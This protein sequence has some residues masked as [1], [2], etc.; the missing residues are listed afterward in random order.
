MWSLI[1]PQRRHQISPTISGVML[2]GLSMGIGTA[3]YN[4]SNNILF[5]ALSLLLA[6]LILSGVLSWLNLM[7]VAWRLLLLPP[8]RVGQQS[9][10]VLELRN[11]KRFLP[12]YGLSFGLCAR[13]VNSVAA[14]AE[15]TFIA[16]S[17]DVRAA[18]AK[19][20]AIDAQGRLKLRERLEPKGDVRLEWALKPA[21]R[22]RLRVEL[23]NVGSLFPFG[24]LKKQVGTDLGTAVVVWPAPI[25][26]RRFSTNLARRAESGA[27]ANRAGSGGDLLALRRYASGDSHRLIHWKATARTRQLLVQQFSAEQIEGF[28]LWLD[29]DPSTW[30]RP[31]QFELLVS[32]VATLAEDLFRAGRLDAFAV[33]NAAVVSIRRV[34]DLELF[35]DQLALLPAVQTPDP[36]LGGQFEEMGNARIERPMRVNGKNLLTFAPD[37]VRGVIAYVDAKKIAAV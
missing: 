21:R 31:A 10:V 9:V 25:E 3:A 7:G 28:T 18:F 20:E 36:A 24:F 13:P 29:T 32:F 22:G 2:I 35:L 33:N 16:R 14:K 6:C 26:Y 37:G 27:R 30:V 5:I 1:F 17:G 8:M 23:D 11:A 34:R 12:T 15:S 4:S 19:A